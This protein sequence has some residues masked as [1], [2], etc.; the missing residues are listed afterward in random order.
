MDAI[1]PYMPLNAPHGPASSWIVRP[2]SGEG[3]GSTVV[4]GGGY[5]RGAGPHLL[6]PTQGDRQVWVDLDR[7]NTQV[8]YWFQYHP[9][10]IDNDCIFK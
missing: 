6:P 4:K 9:F 2:G 8:F 3:L 1:F 10:S 5:L 7:R